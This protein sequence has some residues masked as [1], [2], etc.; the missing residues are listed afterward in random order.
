MADEE[1]TPVEVEQEEQA[2]YQP[3]PEKS[4]DEMLK[5]DEDD[6]A[7][8]KYK[9]SL[10]GDGVSGSGA[11]VVDPSDPRKVILKKLSLV[12][13][14]RDDVSI[15]LTED[16]AVIKKRTFVLKEGVK[17]RMKIDFI[18]QREIVHGLKYVQK[19]YK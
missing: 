6:E 11:V 10:L 12:V 19:T 13:E 16:L 17:F 4:I 3:P 14:G 5:T 9:A 1:N 8:Q 7:L 2:G 18:V 15:D